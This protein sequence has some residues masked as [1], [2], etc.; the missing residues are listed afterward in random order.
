M[1]IIKTILKNKERIEYKG[2]YSDDDSYAGYDLFRFYFGKKNIFGFRKYINIICYDEI[3]HHESNHILDIRIEI[4]NWNIFKYNDFIDVKD[5][6][7]SAELVNIYNEYQA[8]EKLNS[9]N[10]ISKILKENLVNKK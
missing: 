4:P 1:N 6:A 10:N 9:I 7:L 2:Y 5:K 8:Q 3:E